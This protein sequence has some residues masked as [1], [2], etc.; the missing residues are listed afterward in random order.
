MIPL[1]NWATDALNGGSPLTDGE[2]TL[3]AYQARWLVQA[4]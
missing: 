1:G 3:E 2:L 4:A